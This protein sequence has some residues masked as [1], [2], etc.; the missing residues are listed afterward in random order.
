MAQIPRDDAAQAIINADH[1]DPFSYLGI[2]GGGKAG[3]TVRA[4]LPYAQ[5]VDVVDARSGKVIAPMVRTF[6]EGLYTAHLAKHK[7][8]FAYRLRVKANGETQD[9]DDPYAF[10]PVLSEMDRH[11][12]SEGTHYQTFNK[13]GAHVIDI[14]GVS[15]VLFAVWAP[16]AKRVSVV[17]TFNNW[18]GRCH[19]MRL[20]P[21]CG[22]WEIFI[23]ELGEGTLYKF[24]IRARNG[25]VLPLKADPYASFM[26]QAPGTASIVYD[27][28]E[29]NW[30]DDAWM[31]KRAKTARCQDPI[32]I[33]EVHLG[34][35]RRNPEEEMRSLSYLE[36]ADELV[37][38]VK[39]M[40]FTHVELLPVTEFP[41]EGS[42]GYQPIG[43]FAPTSRFGPPNDFR[44]F[45]ERCHDAGIGVI[46]DWVVGH[47][48]EDTHGLGQFDGTHLYEHADPRL[49]RHADWG[50]L[51]Y[52]FGRAEV[53]NYLISNA[54]FWLEAYHID[55][56]RVDAV[57]SMLYLDYSREP[58]EWIPN[59]FGGNENLEAIDFLKRLN[60]QVYSLQPGAFTVAEE[61][62]A[63]PQVSRPTY[64]GGLGFGF[65]W[66][67]G[68][69][70]DTLR[71]IA[72]DPIY[73]QHHMD[74]L[75]FGLLYAFQE[76][77]MLPISHDEVVHGKG[78]LLG[79]MTGDTWQKFA[80]L[81]LY[82][83]F[84]Y[85]HPGKK[86]LFMG[87]EFAQHDEWD[88]DGSLDWHLL[89][90][91]NHKGIQT[92]VRDLN[93]IYRDQEALHIFDNAPEGFSWIECHDHEQTV[94][95]FRRHGTEASNDLFVVCNLTPMVRTD[96]RL[97]VPYAGSYSEV[98]NSDG[99][100]YGGNNTGNCGGVAT[101]EF[102]MHGQPQ[103]LSLTLP[104][105]AVVIL[106]PDQN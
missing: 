90:E 31:K 43:L 73:R 98:F 21:D 59:K 44:V 10:A 72:H 74:D 3:V 40:G 6:S 30:S 24:E 86:L 54:L 33:Y 56:L 53:S 68:W 55:G 57:A 47:F 76:N 14:N 22:I 9:I 27:L 52:N 84:M 37:P 106:R 18:D 89:G 94:L 79:R 60:E 77:F 16:N 104:S 105:L 81:R 39:E 15:G 83:T 99:A 78:S 67:M 69:M 36:M 61:S 5:A 4:F 91:E 63:W 100:S 64:L 87:C 25:D 82:L 19:S 1:H 2:H 51:I 101:E 28:G 42:W 93:G 50:T 49:G 29:Y 66:N 8:P 7:K 71:F 45:V 26:E 11:L 92:L 102:S 23:P 65:K 88:H 103:S 41:F 62:T 35:W 17:G 32:S 12:L 13:L 20:H 75:T 34:S 38:Y 95:A 48:P 58:D 80:N 85:A 96:Y 97:G 46:L 70:H